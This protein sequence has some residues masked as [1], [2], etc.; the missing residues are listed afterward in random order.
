MHSV[1]M[2]RWFSCHAA[3]ADTWLFHGM[4]GGMKEV[5]ILVNEHVNCMIL[6]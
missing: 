2:R 5:V 3:A 6:E 1:D 4:C